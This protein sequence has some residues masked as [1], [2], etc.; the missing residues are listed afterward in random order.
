MNNHQRGIYQPLAESVP[1]YDLSSDDVEEE[2]RSRLPLMIVLALIVVAAFAGVVWLAYNQ[3]VARG[4]SGVAIVI[5]APDGPI[6]TAPTDTGEDDDLRGLKI[7]NE[8][9]PPDQEALISNLA[10]NVPQTSAAIA[11]LA[12][13]TETPPV[14][15]DPDAPVIEDAVRP[16]PAVTPPP[17][18]VPAPSPPIVTAEAP[19]AAEPVAAPTTTALSG[20]AVLQIG[21]YESEAIAEGA[22]ETFK[23]RYAGVVGSLSEDVQRADLGNRGIWYRLRVGPFQGKSDAVAAC[24]RLKAQGA[25]CFVAA[26]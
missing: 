2:E 23:A 6:R 8:P 7:Y 9:V 11:V 3:G 5:N 15:L 16:A 20:G 24:E 1:I 19:P 18:P 17:P 12:P 25:S 21:S 13:T 26:P 10:Q 14:R 4:R 22:W